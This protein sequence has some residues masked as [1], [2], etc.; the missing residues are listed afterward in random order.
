MA[1]QQHSSFLQHQIDLI[2]VPVFVAD[3]CDDGEFRIAA[4]NN[5]HARLTGLD[6]CGVQGRTPHELLEDPVSAGEVVGHYRH[7]IANDGPISYRE[8]IV[9]GGSPMVF[10]TTLQKI[11][12]PASGRHRIVG[13]AVRVEDMP[14]VA[15]DIEFHV[16]MARNSL[17]TLEMLMGASASGRSLSVSERE[18][19]QILCRKALLSLDELDKATSQ[20]VRKDRTEQTEM[21]SA[22]RSLLLH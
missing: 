11:A 7:C 2:A 14:S 8:C 3:E 10:D 5:A 21:S 17:T 6:K 4:I 20:L 12:R 22:I 13:T 15:S 19:T 18:A 9:F 1:F 16:S